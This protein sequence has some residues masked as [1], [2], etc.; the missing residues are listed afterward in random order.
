MF[1]VL[2]SIFITL[3]FW[4]PRLQADDAPGA[5][6]AAGDSRPNF[7]F[8]ITDDISHDDLSVY[9][10][11][12][13]QT[14]NLERLAERGLVFDNAYLTISSC[15]PS[16]CSIITGRYPHN[17][18]APELHTSLPD[19][20]ATF[21]EALR[22]AG[23][24]TV[25]SGKNHMAKPQTLGFVESSSSGPSGSEKWVGHLRDRPKGK[26]FFCWFASRDAHHGFQ[27]N[28]KAPRYEPDKV[29]VPP[30]LYD[31]PKTRKDLSGYY[32][33]V[34]RTDYYVGAL[35]DELER[36]G[37]ADNT[38]LVYCA[39]NGRPFPRCKTYLYESGIKTPLLIAGPGVA[40]GRRTGSLVSS[41]D[42]SATF[43]ELAGVAKPESVQGVSLSP[44]LR[45]P[46]ATV[47]DVAFA[48]RNWHVY[49][50]HERAVRTGDWLYI[51][52]GLPN[53]HNL[54][55]ESAP[56]GKFGAADEIWEMKE[57]HKLKPAQAQVT[58]MTQPAEQLFHVGDDPYQI[59]NLVDDPDQA[60]TLARMR[61]LLDKW[62]EQTGDSQP[63]N[64]T[65]DRQT[66]YEH[67]RKNPER[68]DFAGSDRD[69]M[70]INNP[71]PVKLDSG[72]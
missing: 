10:N 40:Q 67:H 13:I 1:R 69:A 57:Q 34:S 64:L 38:Y 61:G 24:H 48:E 11:D 63:A 14:P 47:R 30:M 56:L 31:G 25:I 26:P 68:G 59:N 21:V 43:L 16:R 70:N 50:T 62:K 23:Y 41:I 7:I 53:E 32:H 5:A 44:I 8:F 52:N 18:G 33:E 22:D 71:G 3:V 2:F 15:S 46:T 37:I 36:Q 54:A 58:H 19:S 55:G 51:W 6:T 27:F 45:D 72:V 60:A 42:Y 20:Q 12:A 28:D 65:P 49:R 17:T 9:A 35:L 4:A 66:I 39:D 29:A